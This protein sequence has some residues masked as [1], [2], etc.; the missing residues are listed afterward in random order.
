MRINKK[1]TQEHAHVLAYEQAHELVFRLA[2]FTR[3]SRKMLQ[4]GSSE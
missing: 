3:Y 2:L 1:H 4:P